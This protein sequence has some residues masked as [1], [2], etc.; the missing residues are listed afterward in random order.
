M[1][2][3]RMNDG[4]IRRYAFPGGYPIFYTHKSGTAVCPPCADLT[5]RDEEEEEDD[6]TPE[7]NYE[8]E[9]LHCD[10]CGEQIESAYGEND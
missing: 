7:V 10:Q 6:F 8:N 2:L 9:H 1:S 4:S 3:Q 5:V